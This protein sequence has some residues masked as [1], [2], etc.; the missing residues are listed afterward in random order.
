MALAAQRR[1]T[2]LLEDRLAG[3]AAEHDQLS[4]DKLALAQDNAVLRERVRAAAN[5]RALETQ[6]VKAILA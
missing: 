5:V 4:Q 1:Q 3:M 2:E 6:T